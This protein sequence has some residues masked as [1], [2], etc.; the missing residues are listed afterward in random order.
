MRRNNK[1]LYE[2]IMRNV[3]REVMR[4]L[5]EWT[6]PGVGEFFDEENDE[7]AERIR[8]RNKKELRTIIEQRIKQ[9]SNNPDLSDIDTSLITDMSYLFD[10]SSV[11]NL[12]LSSWDVSN[13]TDMCYM[14]FGC[15]SLKELNVSNWD[16]SN[17]CI[18]NNIFGKCK[19]LE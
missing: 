6:V 1:A 3:S 4:A 17:V 19:Y 9:N 14:F 8:P 5:N 12:D 15:S 2:K 10:G 16:T 11:I 18:M 13:V 7:I